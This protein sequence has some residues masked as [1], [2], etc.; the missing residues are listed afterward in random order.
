MD[1]C[2]KCGGRIEEARALEQY[3]PK[4]LG[5]SGV[6]LINAAEEE[7]CRQC[8]EAESIL[9]PNLQGL[10]AS[11]ALSR[12]K[13]PLKLRGDEIRFL[14]KAME[15]TGS[16]LA[17]KIGVLKYTISRNENDIEPMSPER[18]KILRL[19]VRGKLQR[20]SPIRVKVSEVL[21]MRIFP[22]RRVSEHVDMEFVLVRRS[23]PK[24]KNAVREKINEQY[25]P[26]IERTRAA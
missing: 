11:I 4:N 17:K 24:R 3:E 19:F 5:I 1:V 13:H 14:R 20:F 18:E 16:E 9:I 26:R 12:I 21:S 25:E 6:V 23:T 10:L 22:W 15:L 8:D 2:S 7:R